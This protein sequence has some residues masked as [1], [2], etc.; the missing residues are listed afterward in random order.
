MPASELST[1][2]FDP[3]SR[4]LHWLTAIAVLIAFILGPEGFGRMV[5]QGIDPATRSDI[6]WHETL[7]ALVFALTLIRLVWLALRAPAPRLPMPAWM[8]TASK[9][10]QGLLWLLLLLVPI[11]ALITLGSHD[12]P[13]TLLGGLRISPLGFLAGTSFGSMVDWGDVHGFLGDTILWLAG[14][15]AAAA[16]Y[17]HYALHDGVL[18]SMLPRLDRRQP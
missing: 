16:L 14:G 12:I 2:H 1:R 11:T 5:R 15:H 3:V 6:V 7:G 8:R 18:A 4:A 13:A 9:I 17:H 10:V